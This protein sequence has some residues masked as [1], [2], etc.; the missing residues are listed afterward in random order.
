MKKVAAK[1]RLSKFPLNLPMYILREIVVNL[2][3]LIRTLDE[4]KGSLAKAK[5]RCLLQNESKFRL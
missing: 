1:L 5:S 2:R 3:R 4:S